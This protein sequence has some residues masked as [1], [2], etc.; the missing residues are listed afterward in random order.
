MDLTGSRL[1]VA[2]SCAGHFV[3]HVLLGLYLT[4]VL[5]IEQVWNKPYEELVALWTLGALLVG[6]GAPLA[7]WLS[8][9]WGERRLM[10][11]FFFSAGL[12][13]VLAGLSDTTGMLWISLALLGLACSIYHPVALSWVVKHTRRTGKVMGFWGL[14]GSIGVATASV[15]A[16]AL[17]DVW[18][19]QTA[20][21][22]PGAVTLALGVAL[23]LTPTPDARSAAAQEADDAD[24]AVDRRTMV[25]AFMA[26]TVAMACAAVFYHSLTTMMPKW[27]GETVFPP[28]TG[29]GTQISILGVGTV[30]TL[31]YLFGSAAQIAG[32]ALADRM[33]LKLLFII[34]YV[35]KLPLPVVAAMLGGW[36]AFVVAAAIVFLMEIGA[37]VENILVARYSPPGRRGLVYGLKFVLAFAAGPVGVQLVAW[38]YGVTGGFSALWYAM[39]GL[40]AVTLAAVICLPADRRAGVATAAA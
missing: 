20:F 36:P 14:C 11:V 19:W 13:S 30:V 29:N 4:L 10:L 15:I 6:V 21:I 18:N 22:L 33:P 16:G 17:A 8:D 2:Y 32:G 35:V 40:I 28:D 23:W 39:A 26:L 37:P 7:G 12:A 3:L 9:R 25:Q 38:C 31:V 27:L 34:T 5:V 24:A 1:I